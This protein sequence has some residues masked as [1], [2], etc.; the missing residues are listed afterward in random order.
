MNIW[1][2][3][4]KLKH[5]NVEIVLKLPNCWIKRASLRFFLFGFSLLAVFFG[6]SFGAATAW[7]AT[8]SIGTTNCASTASFAAFIAFSATMFDAGGEVSFLLA[9]PTNGQR[10]D[11]SFDWMEEEQW[12]SKYDAYLSYYLSCWLHVQQTHHAASWFPNHPLDGFYQSDLMFQCC[13]WLVELAS[14]QLSFCWRECQNQAILMCSS[15]ELTEPFCQ[16][17][18][19][20]EGR[21]RNGKLLIY[22]FEPNM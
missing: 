8:T 13:R 7:R 17:T 6:D 18:T 2:E 12:E 9:F 20:A 14:L 3:F 22:S 5:S 19:D 16:Q 10:S 11:Y 1:N 15:F 21:K 4:G